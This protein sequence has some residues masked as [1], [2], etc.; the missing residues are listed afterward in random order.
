[1]DFLQLDPCKD[2]DKQTYDYVFVIVCR[3]S[4]YVIAIPCQ[5]AG[6]TSDICARLFLRNC[7]ALFGLPHEI[8]SDNDHLISSKF[9]QTLCS[10][11]GVSQHTSIAYHP[12]GNGRA[13]TAVRSVVDILRKTLTAFPRAW[14]Q[15]LPWALWQLND[16]PGVD[17]P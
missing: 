14:E 12:Q 16:L 3:L 7:V 2:D 11:S 6:L 9:M 17:P 13:E 8:M 10:M 1:M 5:K 4:G 15:A